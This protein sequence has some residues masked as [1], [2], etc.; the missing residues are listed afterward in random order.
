MNLEY[1]RGISWQSIGDI[2]YIINEDNKESFTLDG[3]AKS[4]W[5][6]IEK[7]SLLK[8]ILNVLQKEYNVDRDIIFEDIKDIIN[9]LINNNLI[10]EARK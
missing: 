4:F 10:V 3:V 9:D 5:I 1:Y 7:Y 8:E 2:V 6:L